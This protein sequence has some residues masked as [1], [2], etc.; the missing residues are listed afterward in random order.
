MRAKILSTLPDNKPQQHLHFS[1]MRG[2]AQ[3]AVQATSGVT[4]VVEG[5]H[6]SVLSTVGV[7]GARA[8]G[9]TRG[10]TGLVYRSI[11][12][13]TRV[14]GT[15]LDTTLGG[16][17]SLLDLGEDGKAG[18]AQRQTA[19][20]ILNGVMG[21]R[22]VAGNNS[23]AIPMTFRYRDEALDWSSMPAMPEASGKVLLLI[24]GLCMNDL[25]RHAAQKDQ[26]PDHGTALAS[27]LGYTPVYLHYNSGL[28]I[29]QSGRELA[30]QLERLITHWPVPVE[31]LTVVGHSMGGLLIRSAFHHANQGGLRWP[32]RLKNMIFLGT[33][34]H[35]APLERAG[36]WFE[37]L[38]GSTAYS[39]PFA[40]LG[41]LR[42][43]GITDLRYGQLLDEEQGGHNRFGRRG[44][45]RQTVPLPEAVACYAVAATT[46]AKRCTLADRLV[47]DGLVPLHS[48]LG[49]HDDAQ[50]R[51]SFAPSSQWI[52]Y[53]MSHMD[54]LSN[55]EVT[56]QIVHWLSGTQPRTAIVASPC[57][58]ERS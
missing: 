40:S 31:E 5:V 18:S 19:M 52:A 47:G 20:A 8:E 49:H 17:E 6:Q 55:P 29:A 58:S 42:S 1:D 43:A 4:R 21:D 56:R 36:N 9:K 27:A 30:A 14:V 3:L 23:F 2:L 54:L 35:G 22:L 37:V 10:I 41:Q 51:L 24:H 15:G 13:V 28:H 38:L 25:Q 44:D 16:L 32:D 45:Q 50:R 26:M 53:R 33:P 11:H 48:A 57:I 7:A 12:A 34:H 46:A 39:K